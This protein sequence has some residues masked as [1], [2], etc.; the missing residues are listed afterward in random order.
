QIQANESRLKALSFGSMVLRPLHM[1]RQRVFEN[2]EK[3]IAF[4][5][6]ARL[7]SLHRASE[8]LHI[9]QPSLSVKIR[10]LEENLDC[11]FFHRSSKGVTLTSKGKELLSFARNLMQMSSKLSDTLYQENDKIKGVLRLGA[12]ESIGK[13]FWPGFY[14]Y[15]SKNYP[16]LKVQLTVGRSRPLIEKVIEGEIDVALTIEPPFHNQLLNQEIYKDTFSIYIHPQ[17]ATRLKLKQSKD[18]KF[19][20]GKDKMDQLSMISFSSA[21]AE[22]G[23][24]LSEELVRLGL[25]PVNLTEVD[26]FDLSLEFCL[27]KMGAAVLPERVAQ[28]MYDSGRLEKLQIEKM[29]SS[30]FSKH[31]ICVSALKMNQ[32]EPL[33]SFFLK[34]LQSTD[35]LSH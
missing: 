29:K 19:K 10:N 32:D 7:G 35:Y 33:I 12:Y 31:K 18:G 22:N 25:L 13:Y 30:A 27:Q 11:K 23:H 6:V 16:D 26:S 4:E 3:I 2:L 15:L 24:A 5:A 8:E 20:I 28:A 14:R 34:E 21:L 17:L 1:N 9:S